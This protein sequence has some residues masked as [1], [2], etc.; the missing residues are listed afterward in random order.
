MNLDYAQRWAQA[1]SSDTEAFADLYAADLDF[2]LE[3]TMVDDHM[4]DTIFQRAQILERL[5]GFANDDAGNGLGIHTFTAKEYIGDERFGL[6]HWDYAVEHLSSFRGHPTDG[7]P[8]ETTGSTFL[9]FNGEGK[10]VL[11]S[12][13]M[14]DN[15][16]F[17]AI[18]LPIMTVHYWDKDF[19]P[20]ALMA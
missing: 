16:I 4:Q 15:P 1:R 20:A 18:G 13:V 8:L 6:I 3:H 19:D 9:R 17:Q 5:G 12:T 7:Q 11:D 2:C 10:I 14:N